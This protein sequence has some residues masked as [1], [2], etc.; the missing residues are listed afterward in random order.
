MT[1]AL[2]DDLSILYVCYLGLTP[3]QISI[4]NVCYLG[5]TPPHG[6][7]LAR[8]PADPGDPD[9]AAGRRDS[10][11]GGGGSRTV[12]MPLKIGTRMVK[13]GER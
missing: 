4:L 3:P 6:I 1:E 5:L 7:R 2:G 8:G 10:G 12:L 13:I 11:N 9:G